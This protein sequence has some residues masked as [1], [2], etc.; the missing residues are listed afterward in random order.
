MFLMKHIIVSENLESIVFKSAGG[1]FFSKT[2]LSLFPWPI[3]L[4]VC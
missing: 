2:V 1:E 3:E 4:I